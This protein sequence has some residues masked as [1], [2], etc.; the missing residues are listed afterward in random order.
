MNKCPSCKEKLIIA[1]S[2]CPN[3]AFDLRVKKG[4]GSQQNEIESKEYISSGEGIEWVQSVFHESNANEGADLI[5]SNPPSQGMFSS[6]FYFEGRI[7][8]T[9]YGISLILYS[10]V[11]I[12]LTI[13]IETGEM[14]VVLIFVPMLLFLWAQGAKRCHDIGRSGWYQFIPFFVLWMLFADSEDGINEYGPNPK[15]E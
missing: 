14:L 11:S 5:D 1:H 15:G 10:I 8:R 12:F 7:R 4:R 13:L 3:C 6:P 9:E 2:F